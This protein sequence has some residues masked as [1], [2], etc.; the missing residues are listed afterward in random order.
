MVGKLGIASFLLSSGGR[1]GASPSSCSLLSAILP[2]SIYLPCPP[3]QRSLPLWMCCSAEQM[4]RSSTSSCSTRNCCQSLGFLFQCGRNLG[5]VKGSGWCPVALG[6]GECDS[7]NLLTGQATL[8][9]HGWICLAFFSQWYILLVQSPGQERVHS[10]YYKVKLTCRCWHFSLSCVK[11][12]RKRWVM[13]KLET[14]LP[15]SVAP[16]QEYSC[17][18]GALS[19]SPVGCSPEE[20]PFL[21]LHCSGASF[22]PAGS[23]ILWRGAEALVVSTA[24][25]QTC[26]KA[27]LWSFLI[28]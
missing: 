8:L 4:R 3:S 10:C 16:Q 18:F 6:K 14:L 5:T 25:T 1:R 27:W 13:L 11:T 21:S 20:R 17:W 19:F 9:V 7:C 12:Q 24:P 22:H 28:I 15:I 2:H 23:L 26:F